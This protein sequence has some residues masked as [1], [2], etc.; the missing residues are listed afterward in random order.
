MLSG[1]DVYQ[2]TWF[3]VCYYSAFKTAVSVDGESCDFFFAQF[4]VP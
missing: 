3:R 1:I 4:G 2:S